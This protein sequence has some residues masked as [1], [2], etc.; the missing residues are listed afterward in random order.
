MDRKFKIV[1]NDFRFVIIFAVFKEIQ[2]VIVDFFFLKFGRGA[3]NDIF[4]IFDK[5]LNGIVADVLRNFFNREIG[6]CYQIFRFC[7]A[8]LVDKCMNGNIQIIPK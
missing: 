8:G 3:S 5:G 4:E 1:L 6:I 7:D 2:I